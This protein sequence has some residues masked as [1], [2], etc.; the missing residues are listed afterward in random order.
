SEEDYRCW[1]PEGLQMFTALKYH[2]VESRLCMFRG[3]TH[4]L[5]RSGKPKHRIRRL[6]EITSWFNRFLKEQ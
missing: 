2:G 3:E 5:S 6:E 1:L 4:E